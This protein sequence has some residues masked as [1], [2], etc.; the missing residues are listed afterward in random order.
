[1]NFIQL[2]LV[3]LAIQLVRQ[4]PLTPGGVGVVEV[5]LL[6]GLTSIGVSGAEAAAIVVLYRLIAAWLMV[7]TGY[8]TL[9]WLRRRQP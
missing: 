6:T 4:I 5:A 3:Y 9:L 2:A 7:P 8:L 1:V